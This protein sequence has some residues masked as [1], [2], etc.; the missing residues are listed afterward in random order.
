[1]LVISSI[2]TE[3][4]PRPG[5]VERQNN[6]SSQS[7]CKLI[8]AKMIYSQKWF[9]FMIISGHK[10]CSESV[11]KKSDEQRK[12]STSPLMKSLSETLRFSACEGDEK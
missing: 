8:S 1:M 6:A 12:S 3:R 9:I 10:F 2:H 11:D 4:D 7:R 5:A